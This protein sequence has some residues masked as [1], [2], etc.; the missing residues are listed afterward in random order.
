MKKSILRIV[1]LA[2]TAALVCVGCTDDGIDEK[3]PNNSGVVDWFLGV[4]Y[5]VTFNANGGT[6]GDT[7]GTTGA[8][9]DL[10]YL[11]TPTRNGYDFD[12]WFTSATGGTR[13]TTSTFFTPTS[14]VFTSNTTI[15]AHWTLKTYTIA[16][17]TNGGTVDPTSGTTGEGWKLAHLPTPTR[18]GYT[19]DGWY[20]AA[21]GGTE[22]TMGTVFNS[23]ATIYAQWTLNTYKVAF[24]SQGGNV[25]DTQNIGY[26]NKAT[27][28]IVPTR[29]GYTFGGW[30][31]EAACTNAWTFTSDVVTSTVTLYA[32]WTLNT[33]YA[34]AF[35][36]TVGNKDTAWIISVEHGKKVT[37]PADPP[38]RTGY[39]F[40]GWYNGTAKWDFDK[41]IVTSAITLDAKW[42]LITYTVTFNAN[43]GS[44]TPVSGTTGAGGTLAS[45]PTPTRSGYNFNGWYTEKTGG[46][47]LEA[48]VVYSENTTIYAQW[49]IKSYVVTF[50]YQSG[51][52]TQSIEHGGKVTEP[53]ATTRT[54]YTFGGWYKETAC[55]NAW[56]FATD[57]V[58][59]TV[60]LYAKWTLITYA[61]TFNSQSGSDVSPQS[62]GHG[63]NV[64]EPAIPP[65]RANY[66]FG[67]WY[68]EAAC[69]NAWNFTTDVVTSTVTLY[70][71]WTLNTY[72]V[73]F[74]SQSGSEVSPQSI[75]HGNN[76]TEPAEPTRDGYTFGG[77]YKEAACANAWIFDTDTVTST[78]TLYAKWTLITYTVAFDAN[79]GSVTPESGRTGDGWKL[80]SLPTPTRSD[81]IF[82]GW[83]TAATGGTKVEASKVY[84]ENTTIYAQWGGAT[85]T[86]SRD[87]TT[88]KRVQIGNQVWMAENLNRATTNS[89]CYGNSA[90]SCAKYG[91]LYNWATA[92]NINASNN[93]TTWGGSDVKHQGACPVG[94]HIPSDKE[95]DTL[96]TAVG[97]V[98][99]AGRKLR[100]TSGWNYNGN[101][102]DA[103]GFSALPGGGSSEGSFYDVGN[104]GEWWS[105]TEDDYYSH[106]DNAWN[107]YV[108]YGS[109]YVSRGLSYKTSLRSVRCV[110]D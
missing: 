26:G 23:N 57:V 30:Y 88:Y 89:K 97:G 11:P 85:F 45:L 35:N 6:V 44:V 50:N 19:F 7:S 20:T 62:I 78:V 43:D 64:T 39:T 5:T 15:Y 80:A 60:T 18:T 86:D 108:G 101:G 95:W 69:T 47:K 74:N 27:V 72:T 106:N 4:T 77:W 61:V 25:V 91:R 40:D 70:A 36:S 81:Y 33:S 3:S 46:I 99:T 1:K 71:K 110:A 12:G 82:E 52:T 65:T 102:E 53:A 93:N 24:N 10:G 28:P 87:G 55:I 79:G 13:V 109:E 107:W 67:G 8:G 75:E 21:T 42:T 103:F 100:S 63:N 96:M 37:K 104:F 14:T 49:T 34:V 73:T 76:V 38:T 94:W 105:A 68:K 22:V 66:T 58:T 56:N 90:D 2:V 17:N 84:S 41:D 92:M 32:K 9:R 31:K 48:S 59:S 16:F 29:T 83:F 98:S 51:S 54:G